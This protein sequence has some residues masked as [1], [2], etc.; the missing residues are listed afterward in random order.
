LQPVL[1]V[2]AY[3]WQIDGGDGWAAASRVDSDQV[4]F[5]MLD[6]WKLL[7]DPVIC[8]AVYSATNTV[9]QFPHLFSL[10]QDASTH[11][12]IATSFT[13]IAPSFSSDISHVAIAVREALLALEAMLAI[14]VFRAAAA[15]SSVIGCVL[16]CCVRSWQTFNRLL[17]LER[18]VLLIALDVSTAVVPKRLPNERGLC[19]D[20]A[21][22]NGLSSIDP[23]FVWSDHYL[24]ASD[25]Q[26]GSATVGSSCPSTS[27]FALMSLPFCHLTILTYSIAFITK[28]FE[29]S[30]TLKDTI[31]TNP[32]L[33]QL[34][35][36]AILN[37]AALFVW[38][39]L[40]RRRYPVVVSCAVSCSV[41]QILDAHLRSCGEAVNAVRSCN[42]VTSFSSLAGNVCAGRL[43]C[44]GDLLEPQK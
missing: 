12:F 18:E 15:G 26:L 8:A 41:S 37:F 9:L 16:E 3:S 19:G 39:D 32:S 43:V 38:A 27:S 4:I 34:V 44:E 36:S 6:M 22:W 28:L 42:T 14:D 7:P 17:H 5:V 31:T 25:N 40:V 11:A 10:L 23:L 24:R 1:Q 35:K 33:L 2:L 30:S 20:D 13:C 29:G 21:W